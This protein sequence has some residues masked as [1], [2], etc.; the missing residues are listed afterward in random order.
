M[1]RSS[2]DG[3]VVRASARSRSFRDDEENNRLRRGLTASAASA[4]GGSWRA[5]DAASSCH[6]AGDSAGGAAADSVSPGLTA[7][8]WSR[9]N[10]K[11]SLS[12]AGSRGAALAAAERW[13]VSLRDVVATPDPGCSAM[14]FNSRTT[15]Q[16]LSIIMPVQAVTTPVTIRVL[17]KLNSLTGIPNPIPRRP[18]NKMPIPAINTTSIIE[19]TPRPRPKGS[20]PPNATIPSYCAYRQPAI[21]GVASSNIPSPGEEY[22]PNPVSMWNAKREWQPLPCRDC[23]GASGGNYATIPNYLEMELRYMDAGKRGP[24]APTLGR[25][26]RRVTI[27]MSSI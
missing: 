27:A 17:P 26:G 23:C 16:R 19:I 22:S 10:G 5:R 21:A 3:S 20:Q 2:A 7:P 18:A 12:A 24:K 15:A 1:R 9:P 14:F 6:G 13:D 11:P 25:R 8:G 4:G